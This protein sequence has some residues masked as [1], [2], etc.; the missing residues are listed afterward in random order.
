LGGWDALG[1]WKN[2][3]MRRASIMIIVSVQGHSL[4]VPQLGNMGWLE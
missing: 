1:N 4:G 3:R 2:E